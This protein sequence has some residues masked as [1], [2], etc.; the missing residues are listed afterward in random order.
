ME[1]QMYLVGNRLHQIGAVRYGIYVT[2]DRVDEF[3]GTF[4]LTD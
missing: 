3:F 1:Y 2:Q 4:E